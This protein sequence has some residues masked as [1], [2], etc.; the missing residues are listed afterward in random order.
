MAK[1]S[2]EIGG[3]VKKG[4]YSRG[5]SD[6][7]IADLYYGVCDRMHNGHDGLLLMDGDS[8]QSDR[9]INLQLLIFTTVVGLFGG[10]HILAWNGPFSSEW[11][12]VIW[13]CSSLFI[14]SSGFLVLGIYFLERLLL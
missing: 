3:L 6:T 11:Q 8:N 5:S 14:T 12:K 9:E 4:E 13:C 1:I 2:A 10:L 7:P